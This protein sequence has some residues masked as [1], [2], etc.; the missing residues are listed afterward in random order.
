MQ[1]ILKH[2][3][4]RFLFTGSSDLGLSL[5]A[6]SAYVLQVICKQV[7]VQQRFVHE[8]NKLFSKE[9][10][11]D[12]A[13]HVKLVSVFLVYATPWNKCLNSCISIGLIVLIGCSGPGCIFL[14]KEED[15]CLDF[16]SG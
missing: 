3:I 7:W 13:L 8:A 12:P 16:I 5:G 9:G 15:Y 6:L 11:L 14:S 10:L 4:C 2:P 1:G